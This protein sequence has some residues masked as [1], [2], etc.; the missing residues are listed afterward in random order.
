MTLYRLNDF[1]RVRLGSPV[2]CDLLLENKSVSVS[3]TRFLSLFGRIQR[4]VTESELVK[5]C[6]DVFDCDPATAEKTVAKLISMRI[7]QDSEYEH[8]L[9]PEVRQWKKYGWL[10]A[11]VL[12][13]RSEGQKYSDVIDSAES[14]DP[15]DLLRE[16]I[17]RHGLPPFWKQVHTDQVVVLPQ[18]TN[19]PERDLGE[20]LLSRRTHIPWSG[21]KMDAGQVSR[22]LLDANRPLVAMRR[23]AE[24]EY[25]T[26]PSALLE[27][28][29]A[30]LE[31]YFVA[32]DVV[33]IPA[34]LYHYDP[35]GHRL[36]LVRAG[37]LREEVR[38]AFT[39]QERASSGSCALLLSAVWERHMLR[40]EGDPRAYRTLLTLVGQFAQRYLVALTAFGFTSFPTP[41]HLPTLADNLIGT[42]RFEESSLYL[43]SAG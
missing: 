5:A 34:G 32:F 2:I 1:M 27:N 15:D 9:M 14:R 19:Y 18:P 4:S 23:R 16:R 28:A 42:N 40:Y 24:N 30:D 43:V 6:A 26:R 39:G 11:L 20:V 13:C 22:M 38:S 31:T 25:Q 29:Y 33:G 10:D 12:H 21:Q 37:N 41:A 3:D 36:S 35:A 17:A 7:L 8:P